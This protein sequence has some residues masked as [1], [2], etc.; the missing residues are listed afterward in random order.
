MKLPHLHA[1]TPKWGLV[2]VPKNTEFCSHIPQGTANMATILLA[3]DHLLVAQGIQNLIHQSGVGDVDSI[4]RSIAE[5]DEYLLSNQPDI[6]LLDV[7]MPDGN[8]LYSVPRWLE[9]YPQ[10]RILIFSTF[11]EHNVIRWALDVGCHGYVLKDS[12]SEDFIKGISEVLAGNS[13]LCPLTK[14]ILRTSP[15]KH[16]GQLTPREL[17]IL[18]LIVEGLPMKQISDRLCLSFETVHGYTK[19]LRTKLGVN[20]TASLVRKALEQKL[21]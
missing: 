16:Q 8:A 1:N 6:L 11:A 13:Y 19:F 7:G 15:H 9:L 10:M 3:D 20:N 5:C 17:E 4:A 2:Y 21:V 12:P 14:E 18:K